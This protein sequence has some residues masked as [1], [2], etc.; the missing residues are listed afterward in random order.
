METKNWKLSYGLPNKLFFE[1]WDGSHHFLELSYGNWE[2]SYENWW[3][4][5]PLNCFTDFFSFSLSLFFLFLFFH[6]YSSV[7]LLTFSLHL[8]S[9]FLSTSIVDLHEPIRHRPK[10]TY[11]RPISPILLFDPS[12]PFRPTH[13]RQPDLSSSSPIF[14]AQLRSSIILIEALSSI[15]HYRPILHRRPTQ[16]MPYRRLCVCLFML[17]LILLWGY[18]KDPKFFEVSFV[19]GDFWWSRLRKKIGDLGWGHETLLFG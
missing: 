14:E 3:T 11:I 7:S 4:K 8:H 15:S 5:R 9:E 10:L 6:F 18:W 2:L 12:C 19:I 1:N 16:A 13:H 17:L